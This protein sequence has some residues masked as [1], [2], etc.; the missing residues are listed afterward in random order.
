MHKS[1]PLAKPARYIPM[2]E[3]PGV[4][5]FGPTFTRFMLVFLWH[6]ALLLIAYF[7]GVF[8]SLTLF[9]FFAY[10]TYVHHGLFD[11]INVTYSKSVV[12]WGKG[13][14]LITYPL[15]WVLLIDHAYFPDEMFY[16][17]YIIQLVVFLP[18][19]AI[20]VLFFI[21]D[22]EGNNIRVVSLS[23]FSL[24]F[25][26]SVLLY[27]DFL[28][29]YSTLDHRFYCELWKPFF[30]NLTYALSLDGLNVWFL[31]L[32]T[33]L[34]FI[35][36]LVSWESITK[37]R[38]LFFILLFLL[39]FFLLNMFL[40][41]EVLLFY[42]Y[43]EASAIP[44]FLF[45]GIWGS[46]SRRIY[47]SF[48]FLF[49]TLVGSILMFTLLA[50]FYVTFGTTNIN[51][52][53]SFNYP[54]IFQILFFIAF[55]SSFAVKI[56]MVPIHLWLP[57]AHVE[58]PTGI[59]VLLAG[60]LLKTG[61]YAFI[62]FVLPLCSE[63]VVFFSPFVYLLSIVSIVYGSFAAIVQTD[64]KKMIA[65]SSVAH[66]N[67]ATIGIFSGS[68]AGLQ[69]SVYLM[70]THGVVSSGLFI[71]VGVLY[72]RYHTRII[73]YY[74]GLVNFMPW[75]ALFFLILILANI[76]F[77][78]TA[79]FVAEFILLSDIFNKNILVSLLAGLGIILGAIY[80][81]WLYNRVMF[82]YVNTYIKTY[83]D[84]NYREYMILVIMLFFV[85]LM[86]V[87]PSFFLDI[88]YE[89]LFFINYSVV[90]HHL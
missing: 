80:S 30:M 71:C 69:G 74:G 85:V 59:S 46:T 31:I 1:Y 2:R 29:Q 37:N 40:V 26:L 45:I 13:L 23:F 57:E 32:T 6:L 70:L 25:L 9:L 79:S 24:I 27:V 4:G 72:D 47:A 68:L 90:L 39:E 8:G 54:I 66:M 28:W 43:F 55:F 20:L 12:Q 48:K 10:F 42:V 5:F 36:C 65:Y 56:P 51:Y 49:Y 14:S 41:E 82:G 3:L 38:K 60:I 19:I 64:L 44:M 62:K 76:S 17:N 22:K 21:N 7:I 33:F 52:L 81:V 16:T 50:W 34:F 83:S 87:Y 77:P 15:I 67:V 11:F 88:V 89:K 84:L 35:V 61:G 18:L 58:A 73:R 78:S 75:F 86:G 63:S 53:S